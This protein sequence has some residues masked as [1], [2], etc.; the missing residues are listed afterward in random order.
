M[1]A[2]LVLS[3]KEIRM[4]LAHAEARAREA[5]ENATH[6]L[7]IRNINVLPDSTGEMQVLSTTVMAAVP[8]DV[9]VKLIG[10]N[11]L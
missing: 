7:I 10:K 9:R 1:N 3:V 6:C 8:L 2:Y 11:D 4:L 5:K